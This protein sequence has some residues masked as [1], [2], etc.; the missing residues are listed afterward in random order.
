MRKHWNPLGGATVETKNPN[1][2]GRALHS[3]QTNHLGS[4]DRMSDHHDIEPSYTRLT[5]LRDVEPITL[6]WFWPG[7]FPKGMLSIIAAQQ[8]CGKSTLISDIASR[9]SRGIPCTDCQD[10]PNPVGDVILVNSEDHRGVTIRNR[11]DAA[12]CDPDRIH[13]MDGIIRPGCDHPGVFYIDQHLRYLEEN[14]NDHSDTRLVIFDTIDYYLSADA[15]L[16]KKV[17][18]QSALV[19]LSQLAERRGVT[20]I[21]T[22]HLRKAESSIAL[23]K[24]LGS[25]G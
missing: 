2:N 13:L 4:G 7:R 23:H 10:T 9:T 22:L 14:L 16:D 24:I 21:G 12:G 25:V 8:G 15:N 11:F 3:Q 5:T 19:L 1:N 6:V 17:D 18:V 20:I